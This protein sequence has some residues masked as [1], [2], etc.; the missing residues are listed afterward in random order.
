[1]P[2]RQS[3]TVGLSTMADVDVIIRYPALSFEKSELVREKFCD[4]IRLQCQIK[5]WIKKHK[6]TVER[7]TKRGYL[8]YN[9]CLHHAS[10]TTVPDTCVCSQI[11]FA[12]S[13]IMCLIEEIH[14]IIHNARNKVETV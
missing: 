13:D 5:R 6:L 1:M 3:V 7:K 12:K 9:E 11:R 8:H 14:E 2:C 10:D 4:V